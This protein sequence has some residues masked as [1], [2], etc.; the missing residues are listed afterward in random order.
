MFLLPPLSFSRLYTP[1]CG[2]HS[3]CFTVFGRVLRRNSMFPEG[4][5]VRL[6][7]ENVRHELTVGEHSQYV[8]P[9]LVDTLAD[10]VTP[11]YITLKYNFVFII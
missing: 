2:F 11:L 4:P 5:F 3:P 9:G 10:Y 6:P 7:S 1:H 8:F